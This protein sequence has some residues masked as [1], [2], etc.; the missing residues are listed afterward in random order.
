MQTAVNDVSRLPTQ[1]RHGYIVKVANA[2]LAEEDDY[3]LRFDGQNGLD[4]PGSWNE[5]SKPSIPR[6]LFN[7]PLA[8]QRTGLANPGNPATE[9]ATFTVGRFPYQDR[10][11]GD[12]GTNPYPSFVTAK[13]VQTSNQLLDAARINKVIFFRNRFFS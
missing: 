9:I 4:G 13:G 3:Y 6:R 7:M 1:C 11:V 5:C 2:R 8:I 12:N 10:L